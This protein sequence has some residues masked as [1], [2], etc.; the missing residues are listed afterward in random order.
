M[1]MNNFAFLKMLLFQL[2]EI[3]NH[4]NS[5]LAGE[6]KRREADREK[7]VQEKLLEISKLGSDLKT[8]SEKVEANE[9]S[10]KNKEDELNVSMRTLLT[11][12]V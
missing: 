6:W 2:K 8:A 10:L 9:R 7:E 5:V 4:H 3:E 11:R 1:L 12:N